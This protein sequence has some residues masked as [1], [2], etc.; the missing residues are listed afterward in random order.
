M[1][2]VFMFQGHGNIISLCFLLRI[3]S[4]SQSQN[5][6][7]LF[8]QATFL[9]LCILGSG[10]NVLECQTSFI[11]AIFLWSLLWPHI[12]IGKYHFFSPCKESKQKMSQ[13]CRLY[14]TG[15]QDGTEP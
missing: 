2:A 5:F 8:Y 6:E 13:I 3:F 1:W 4:F 14:H 12:I 11:L 10:G 9:Y 15:L 7:K